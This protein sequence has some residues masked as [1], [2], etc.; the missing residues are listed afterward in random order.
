ML[1]L[2]CSALSLGV[3]LAAVPLA[4]ED[5]A[6]YNQRGVELSA[7]GR[8]QEAIGELE[9]ALRL[10]PKQPVVRRNLALVHANYGA[11]LL[12][13]RTFEAAATEYQ[14]AIELLPEEAAF[15]MGLGWAFLGLQ[16]PD[17][18]VGA[19]RRARD[20]DPQEPMVY[21]LLGEAHYHRGDMAAAVMAWEEGLRLRPGDRELEGLINKADGELETAAIRAA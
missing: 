14:A 12:Q 11:F 17:R 9:K 19:L 18:A 5:V 10:A 3:I 2:C 8:Y 16:E 6:T 7:K 20:L 4:A 21:R 1:R 13:K 15:H